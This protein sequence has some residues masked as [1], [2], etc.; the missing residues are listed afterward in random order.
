MERKT[1][2]MLLQF[3]FF[4]RSTVRVRWAGSEKMAQEDG[5]LK[6]YEGELRD[7]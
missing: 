2:E 5:G 7:S 4:L 6:N 3:L 1:K